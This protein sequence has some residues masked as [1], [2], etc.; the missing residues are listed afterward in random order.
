MARTSPQLGRDIGPGRGIAGDLQAED[1][2]YNNN[3]DWFRPK[4]FQ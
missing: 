4:D 2:T 1:L 3:M